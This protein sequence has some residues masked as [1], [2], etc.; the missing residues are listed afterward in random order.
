[1][2]FGPEHPKRNPKS[3]IY[4]PK[5]DDEHPRPFHMGVPTRERM[6]SQAIEEY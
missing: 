4:T 3:E 2:V 6:F 1:M 5:P